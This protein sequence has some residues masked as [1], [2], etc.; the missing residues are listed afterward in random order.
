MMISIILCSFSGHVFKLAIFDN[1]MV[2]II[3]GF[4]LGYNIPFK[5]ASPI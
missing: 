4:D 2:R 1:I 5:F 3:E